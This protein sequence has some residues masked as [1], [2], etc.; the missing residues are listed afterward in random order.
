[1]Y[2]AVEVESK[3]FDAECDL[4]DV[5]DEVRSIISQHNALSAPA[6]QRYPATTHLSIAP[7][8]SSIQ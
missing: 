2:R 7:E 3:C 4:D 6:T 5:R 1:M 8:L